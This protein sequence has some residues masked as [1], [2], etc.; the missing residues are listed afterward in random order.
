MD[1]VPDIAFM[2][3]FV[4]SGLVFF[5]AAL[6]VIIALKFQRGG[7]GVVHVDLRR[8]EQGRAVRDRL[9][10]HALHRRPSPSRSHDTS[11]ALI[12]VT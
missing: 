12:V 10:H 9:C 1:V 2:Y 4:W 5:S 8:R 3:G 7:L 11:A 6:N